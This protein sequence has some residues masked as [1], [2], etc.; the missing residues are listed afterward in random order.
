MLAKLIRPNGTEKT[1]EAPE[2][3]VS[4]HGANSILVTFDD[5]NQPTA[6]EV[7]KQGGYELY[8]MNSDGRTVET[9]RWGPKVE[10]DEEERDWPPDGRHITLTVRVPDGRSVEE[11]VDAL[12]ERGAVGGYHLVAVHGNPATVGVPAPTS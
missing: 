5:A 10:N 9:Y 3:T 6:W 8:L 2:I 1:R 7:P 12:E 11:A 4:S